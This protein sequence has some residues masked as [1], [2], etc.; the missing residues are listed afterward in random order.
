MY[1]NARWDAGKFSN[2]SDERR[3]RRM[4]GRRKWWLFGVLALAVL[5]AACAPQGEAPRSETTGE[6]V[7]NADGYVDITVDQLQQMLQI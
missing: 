1:P 5:I 3:Y 4:L 2:L 6:F 7:K